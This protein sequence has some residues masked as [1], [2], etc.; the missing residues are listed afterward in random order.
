MGNKIPPNHTIKT[1]RLPL[2]NYRDH[3]GGRCPCRHRKE[4]G[5]ATSTLTPEAQPLQPFSKASQNTIIPSPLLPLQ[6][7]PRH[8]QQLTHE[9]RMWG[10]RLLVTLTDDETLEVISQGVKK[11]SLSISSNSLTAN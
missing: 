9:I 8:P 10:H 5:S 6:K 7:Y 2:C 1:E 11:P 4:A 3:P